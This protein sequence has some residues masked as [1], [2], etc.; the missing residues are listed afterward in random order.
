MSTDTGIETYTQNSKS[1][2]TVHK[3][4]SE[5]NVPQEI[6]KKAFELVT[7]EKSAVITYPSN[8][9]TPGMKKE[10]A[11]YEGGSKVQFVVLNSSKDLKRR[12]QT[13]I[14]ILDKGTGE[15]SRSFGFALP[16]MLHGGEESTRE[17]YIIRYTQDLKDILSQNATVQVLGLSENVTDAT[18]RFTLKF[19]TPRTV[20]RSD[21]KSIPNFVGRWGEGSAQLL[22]V[23]VISGL[24]DLTDFTPNDFNDILRALHNG[25]IDQGLVDKV[26]RAESY[27][28][29]A[30]QG[31]KQ[32]LL[33]KNEPP[34]S[35]PKMSS[36]NEK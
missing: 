25:K 18:G 19:R 2:V 33:Q 23:S 10:D 12:D 17:V 1:E 30:K 20:R 4:N 26:A 35:L 8:H 32:Q 11:N 36:P 22:P 15:M 5:T 31:N 7:N 29:W 28:H 6:L 24:G 34:S 9:I 27:Y 3:E 14:A 21:G 13:S 16:R